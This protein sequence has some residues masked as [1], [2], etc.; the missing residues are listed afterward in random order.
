MQVSNADIVLRVAQKNRGT[1]FLESARQSEFESCL[2]SAQQTASEGEQAR[3]SVGENTLAVYTLNK[4]LASST[5]YY[6]LVT[7]VKSVWILSLKKIL[8]LDR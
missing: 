6:W 7:E 2:R 3:M 1:T 8:S 4:L 5:K